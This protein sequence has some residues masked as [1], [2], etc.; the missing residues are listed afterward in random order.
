MSKIESR[1]KDLG[2]VLPDLPKPIANYVPAKRTGNIIHTAGK[3]QS[4]TP[5]DMQ[6]D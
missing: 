1:L 2:I 3:F 5:K 4:M 6:G